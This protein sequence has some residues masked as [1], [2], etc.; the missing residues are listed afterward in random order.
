MNLWPEMER[1]S[2][3]AS[4][5]FISVTG[6]GGK[7]TFLIEF[8]SFLK[9]KGKSVLLTT[10]TKLAPESKVDYNVDYSFH[11][12]EEVKTVKKGESALFAYYDREL[13]KLVSP[14]LCDISSLSDKF[15]VV[16][17]E[18]DGSRGRGVKI[19][20]SRDPVIAAETTSVVSIIGLGA[21][22]KRRGDAVFGDE[23]KDAVDSFY[24]QRV[25]ESPQGALKGMRDDTL[26]ILLLNGGDEIDE[27]TMDEMMSL[28]LP[29]FVNGYIVSVK[30]GVIYRA[31]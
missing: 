15:D 29:P 20:S 30:K 9:R 13:D 16:I 6:G 2:T 19:H 17:A 24:I 25:I 5:P 23:G 3:C 12:L 21:L 14:P 22:G 18:A 10:T 26:N 1:I 8:S 4:H 28:S 27:I 31:L 7:T 11:T